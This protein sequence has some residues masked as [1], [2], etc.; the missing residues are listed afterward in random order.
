MEIFGLRFGP[1]PSYSEEQQQEAWRA[2]VR[3]PHGTVIFDQLLYRAF[4]M[5]RV[6]LRGLGEQDLLLYIVQ[7][8]QEAE[9]HYGGGEQPAD[10]E[11]PYFRGIN[12]PAR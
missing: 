4:L 10:F 3:A 6:D 1:R 7:K 5:R 11:H 9:A 12:L 2:F 8:I